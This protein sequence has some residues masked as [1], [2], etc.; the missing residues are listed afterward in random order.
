[1]KK[2]KTAVGIVGT[3]VKSVDAYLAAV[4]SKAR[5]A[6]KRLRDEVRA[7]APEATELIS[8]GMPAFKHKGIL[9]YYAAFKDHCS[10][11]PASVAAMRKHAAQLKKYETTGKGT[12]RFSPDRPLPA[13]LVTS[14]VKTRIAENEAKQAA[15]ERRKGS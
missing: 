4:P 7:A 3:Q 8:Y 10:F 6:L 5:K 9:V 12:I 14:L 13:R 1:M 2:T 11:F 15:R